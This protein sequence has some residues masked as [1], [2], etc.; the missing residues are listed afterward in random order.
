MCVA[1]DMC[2]ISFATYSDKD[3][4]ILAAMI[5][6]ALYSS[7]HIDVSSEAVELSALMVVL[8]DHGAERT[9]AEAMAQRQDGARACG[10]ALKAGANVKRK[11]KC[12]GDVVSEPLCAVDAD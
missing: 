7:E 6:M 2:L 10:L 1:R 12:G 5:M 9:C 4:L 8:I 11:A 3:S